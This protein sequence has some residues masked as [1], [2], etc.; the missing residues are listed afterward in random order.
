MVQTD[1]H[2]LATATDTWLDQYF[3]ISSLHA[4]IAKVWKPLAGKNIAIF[5]GTTCTF[6]RCHIPFL[7]RENSLKITFLDSQMCEKYSYCTFTTSSSPPSVHHLSIIAWGDVDLPDLLELV[8]HRLVI[9][10]HAAPPWVPPKTC[11]HR[12]GV[13]GYGH[14]NMRC[15]D[16]VWFTA[17]TAWEGTG[18]CYAI[19]QKYPYKLYL[20]R[21]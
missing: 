3:W 10:R 16:G 1:L 4:A 18:K 2:R 9:L 19:P 11:H 20:R 15:P 13:P 14:Q 6:L 5:K 12:H 21:C 17:S 8:R 7:F